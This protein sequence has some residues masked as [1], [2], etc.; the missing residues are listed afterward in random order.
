MSGE[1]V[2]NRVK[3]HR[4]SR[5]LSEIRKGLVHAAGCVEANCTSKFY[6]DP[7]NLGEVRGGTPISVPR[8]LR[9]IIGRWL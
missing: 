2:K 6:L 4:V 5:Q 9:P 3:K 1:N 8:S 7:E